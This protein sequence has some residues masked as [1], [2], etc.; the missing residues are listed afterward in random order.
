MMDK[1]EMIDLLIIKVNDLLDARGVDKCRLGVDVIQRLC[2]LKAGLTE[3]DK[4]R[5]SEA[6]A[7]A[8][9]C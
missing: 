5:E 3:E 4:R 2:A 8:H 6:H 1:F 7:E 9:S